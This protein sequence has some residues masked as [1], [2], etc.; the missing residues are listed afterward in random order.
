VLTS[1]LVIFLGLNH[2]PAEHV[3]PAEPMPSSY[4]KAPLPDPS[5]YVRRIAFQNNDTTDDPVIIITATG[6]GIHAAAWTAAALRAIDEEFGAL[7]FHSHILLVSSVSGGSVT[8]AAFLR[9]YF[10]D[11]AFTEA[12]YKRI[13]GASVC[14]S[15]QAVAW[16]LAY[17]DTLRLLFPWFFNRFPTLD[18]FD[19]GWA[20]QK[21]I[22]RNLRDLECIPDDAS[23]NAGGPDLANFTL[24][25]MAVRDPAGP[26][27]VQ[28]QDACQ[29][30][31]A[32]T[33]NATV[34]ETGD[35]FL[36]SNYSVFAGK[37]GTFEVLPAASFLGVYGRETILPLPVPKPVPHRGGFADL[38][39]LTAARLS[40]TFTYISP[41]ARLPF[42]DAQGSMQNAYHF[43]DGGYY[44]NDGTNS[45]IEFLKAASQASDSNKS[46]FNPS[47][48]LRVLLIEIRNSDDLDISDSPDSYAY[49]SG[50]TWNR[51]K[52]DWYPD[53]ADSKKRF[54]PINQALAPPE[55][56]IAAGFS[57]TTRRNRRELDTL[58][59]ALCGSLELNHV[60]LDYQQAI[61]KDP[62]TEQIIKGESEIAQ[63]L[64]WH[65]TKRE[66][67]WING[68]DKIISAFD[69]EEPVSDRQKIREAVAWF[70]AAQSKNGA[71][72]DESPAC[73][74][75]ILARSH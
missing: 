8:S 2:W 33:L 52:Q 37:A 13:Q 3:F 35:R 72:I 43:V 20:L 47:R 17:P 31:P 10:T 62:A 9:E 25:A 40:A 68:G 74:A 67:N 41:A 59:S 34:V 45:A 73:K 61:K 29:H 38:S 22:D 11:G 14:S 1:A 64:S 6:G 7:N 75:Q 24:N 46:T 69:R 28:H 4:E 60:V 16:G 32:F 12:S 36:L 63:P 65:L 18:R 23:R 66:Q 70:R 48:P 58:E 56:A 44:D 39:L 54:G 57:S 15:L 55:A 27:C 19:R 50:L 5:D 30:L 26:L 51:A 49:E 21:A 53:Q 42:E 71:R